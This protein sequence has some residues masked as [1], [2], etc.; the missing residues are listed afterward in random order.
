MVKEADPVSEYPAFETL[1]SS[2][3]Q[4]HGREMHKSNIRDAKKKSLVD[5]RK[6]V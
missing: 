6:K 4:P 2:F 1:W 5:V 3:P